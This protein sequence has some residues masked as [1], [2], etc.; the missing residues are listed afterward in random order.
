MNKVVAVVKLFMET[1]ASRQSQWKRF[2]YF[3]EDCPKGLTVLR[4]KSAE[5]FNDDALLC[6][7]YRRKFGNL[8][9]R[10]DL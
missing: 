6:I 1:N 7:L 9:L 10:E 8:Y 4:S 5:F 2:K 3:S